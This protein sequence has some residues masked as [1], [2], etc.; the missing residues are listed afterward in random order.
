MCSQHV[1]WTELNWTAVRELQ[2]SSRTPFWKPH[3]KLVSRTRWPP[4][5][6]VSL[7]LHPIKSWRWRAWPINAC[8][9]W[10]D[11]LQVS[12][13]HLSS[14]AVNTAT[15]KHV[16]RTH[17]RTAVLVQFMCCEQTFKPL[18]TKVVL[19]CRRC[20]CYPFFVCVVDRVGWSS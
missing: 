8:R 14:C 18:L 2:F 9:N 20:C 3:Q 4:T 13:V 1:N 11:L 7:G 5:V 6:P 17:L 16:F 10:V 12:L 19:Q 15:G